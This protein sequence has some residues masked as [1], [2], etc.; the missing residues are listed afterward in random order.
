MVW[1]RVM[2]VIARLNIGGLA[3]HVLGLASGM[4]A[5]QFD[6]TVVAGVLC[7]DEGDMTAMLDR[8]GVSY[9][10]IPSMG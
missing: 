3:V 10:I 6:V 5:E 8:V 7:E 9:Q 4:R 1:V 2:H